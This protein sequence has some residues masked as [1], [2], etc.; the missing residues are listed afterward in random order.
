MSIYTDGGVTLFR[1][2]GKKCDILADGHIYGRNG[3][4]RGE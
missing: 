3:R 1:R 4:Q 2:A